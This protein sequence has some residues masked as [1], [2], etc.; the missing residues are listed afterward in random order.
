M[1]GSEKKN[2]RLFTELKQEGFEENKLAKVFAPIG[3]NIYS[4]T[5]RE[6]AVSIAAQIKL[7]KIKTYLR[8]EHRH[9]LSDR[10]QEQVL[11]FRMHVRLDPS[12]PHLPIVEA[13]FK[14]PGSSSH[15]HS[16]R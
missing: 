2:E 11:L 1:P 5:T 10:P 15:N 7:K 13:V 9:L 3:L 16:T 14:T 8:G 6:I 4:K 12:H